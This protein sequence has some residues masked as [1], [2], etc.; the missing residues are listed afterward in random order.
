MT[1]MRVTYLGG[2]RTEMEHIQSGN[3]ITTDAPLDNKGKGE[4]FSPTDLLAS[5]LAS[6]I[7]TTMGISAESYG[8]NIE[9]TRIEI[10]KIMALHPRRVAEIIIDCYL[11]KG[12]KYSDQAKRVIES[13]I[14]TCPVSQSLHPDIIKT[15]R[16]HYDEK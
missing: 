15:V 3:K 4:F 10:E 16:F 2:L 8:F 1:K 14:R 7:L 12:V 6:C 13:T 11:P 9:G 5:S